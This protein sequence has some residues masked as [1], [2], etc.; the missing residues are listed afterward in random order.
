MNYVRVNTRTYD[1]IN[2]FHGFSHTESDDFPM[3]LK[4]KCNFADPRPS[5]IVIGNLNSAV[6]KCSLSSQ[7]C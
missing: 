5:V 1:R 7:I 3:T 2:S 4:I 6:Y